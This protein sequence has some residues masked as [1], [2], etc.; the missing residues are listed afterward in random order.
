MVSFGCAIRYEPSGCTWPVTCTILLCR[1]TPCQ[2]YACGSRLGSHGCGRGTFPRHRGRIFSLAGFVF[3][4][5]EG[6]HWIAIVTPEAE[7]PTVVLRGISYSGLPNRYCIPVAAPTPT[8]KNHSIS[9]HRAG[10]YRA[11][12]SPRNKIERQLSGKVFLLPHCVAGAFLLT[13]TWADAGPA[14]RSRS[15]KSAASDAKQLPLLLEF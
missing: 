7:L 6:L 14:S 15:G 4:R 9:P 12:L 11:R 3:V 5:K 8:A 10:F 13:R 2:F 1:S